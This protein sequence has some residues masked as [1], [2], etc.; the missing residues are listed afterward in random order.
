MERCIYGFIECYKEQ[1]LYDP[2]SVQDLKTAYYNLCIEGTV[3]Q[4][5]DQLN[6]H[7]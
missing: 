1:V 7:I 6:L 3:E 5:E 4:I 2:D